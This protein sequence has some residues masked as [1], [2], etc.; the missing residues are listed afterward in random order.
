MLEHSLQAKS[1]EPKT[2]EQ[3]HE[4]QQPESV[5]TLDKSG[6]LETLR[7]RLGALESELERSRETAAEWQRRAE[8]LGDRVASLAD[9]NEALN[10]DLQS[11]VATEDARRLLRRMTDTRDDVSDVS[12]SGS[13]TTSP[14]DCWTVE[15]SWLPAD[16]PGAAHAPGILVASTPRHMVI[17]LHGLLRD[18][19]CEAALAVTARLVQEIRV[20]P[21]DLTGLR[22]AFDT[23]WA[24]A[25]HTQV[26]LVKFAIHELGIAMGQRIVLAD[27]IACP[28]LTKLI[29]ALQQSRHREDLQ[30][31]LAAINPREPG[32]MPPV[33]II[34]ESNTAWIGDRHAPWFLR[35]DMERRT[36]T[37][38][39]RS[40]FQMVVAPDGWYDAVITC[41]MDSDTTRT[42]TMP[43]DMYSHP[44]FKW[45]TE[46]VT[47]LDEEE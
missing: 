34:A 13:D 12:D 14:S 20:S 42:W 24:A 11:V 4:A 39:H 43:R 1:S 47:T 36:V 6:E 2:V 32:M 10:I 40:L 9:E 23:L 45:F 27:P 16:T 28:L 31:A 19:A 8:A 17:Q 38:I 26:P 44:F 18:Q 33:V 22:A 29:A 15:P 7:A 37:R 35:L 5:E 21:S 30:A 25:C 41:P 46:Y 3:S